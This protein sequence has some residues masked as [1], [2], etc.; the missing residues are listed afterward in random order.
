MRDMVEYSIPYGALGRI[1]HGSF[2]GR[3]LKRIF[4]Y[5]AAMIAR[6]MEAEDKKGGAR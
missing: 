6:L 4:D 3:W 2:V 1:A 5:R